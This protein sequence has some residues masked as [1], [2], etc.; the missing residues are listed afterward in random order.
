M[1]VDNTLVFSDGQ[2]ITADAASTNIID[3]GAAGTAYGAAAAV[4]RDIGKGTEIPVTVLVTEAFTNLTSI[5]VKV[6]VD[7]AAG[8]GTVVTVGQSGEIALA[9]LV[10]GYKFTF[11][12]ELPEGVNKRYV[13]LYYDITGTAPDAGKIFASVVAGRQTNP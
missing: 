9:S 4:S 5:N 10:A 7:D 2:A 1:I 6:Q 13:R 8:F 11:P 12:A 3:I